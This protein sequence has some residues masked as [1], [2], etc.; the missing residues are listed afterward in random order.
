MLPKR[1]IP[2]TLTSIPHKTGFTCNALFIYV[3]ANAE[4]M[5]DNVSLMLLDCLILVN[6]VG[7]LYTAVSCSLA[8]NKQLKHLYT[9]AHCFSWI[10]DT[11]TFV[12]FCLFCFCSKCWTYAHTHT[13]TCTHAQ[14]QVEK[15]SSFK[16]SYKVL[17]IF[18]TRFITKFYVY[19]RS[20]WLS[21]IKNP[22]LPKPI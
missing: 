14:K 11:A 4:Y 16:E 9:T 10:T 18:H 19:I 5:L 3:Y 15:C 22:F 2:V 13:H 1:L 6:G 20:K 8:E 12:F 7:A 17:C 21:D